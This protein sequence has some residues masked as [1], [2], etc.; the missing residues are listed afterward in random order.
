MFSF[1][2]IS[3]RSRDTLSCYIRCMSMSMT[4]IYKFDS[5]FV[6]KCFHRVTDILCL[7]QETAR[8]YMIVNRIVQCLRDLK[9]V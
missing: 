6:M 2:S 3:I 8:Q 1:I 5:E 4:Q 7:V 9:M